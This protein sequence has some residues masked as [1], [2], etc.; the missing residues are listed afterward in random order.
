M[1]RRKF[2]AG[3]ASAVA[4]PFAA[5]AQV[6]N[7]IYRL[8]HLANSSASEAFTARQLCQNLQGLAS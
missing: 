6:P 3:L 4:F 2:V 1:R 7:R 8:G 5:R